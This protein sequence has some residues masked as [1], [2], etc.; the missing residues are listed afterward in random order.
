M[1]DGASPSCAIGRTS[2]RRLG[3]IAGVTNEDGR[4]LALPRAP[5]AIELRH[6]RAF[7]TV[8]EELN[9]GRAA[10]RLYI[11]APALSRQISS[12]EGLVGCELL[13]RSTHRVEL[14]LAGEVLLERSLRLLRDVDDAIST[15]QS[16]GDELAGRAA[17][18]WVPVADLDSSDA[19]FEAIRGAFEALHAQFSPPPEVSTMPVNAGGVPGLLLSS[20]PGLS[21]TLLYL[22]GGG[23]VAGSAF[24]YRHLAGA[25]AVA[26]ETAALVP[27]YRLAPE[28]PF[29]AAIDDA[30]R[31]YLWVLD[32]GTVAAQLTVIADSAGAGLAMSL[33]TKLKQE[34]LPFP[35]AAVLCCP[36]VDLGCTGRQAAPAG[37][38]PVV[39][40]ERA[41]AAAQTYLA[42]HP[43]DD[44]L[45]SPLTADLSGFPPMLIQ[46]ASG[47]DHL[48][49]SHR[50]HDNAR[51]HGVDVRLELYPT[52]T[53]GFHYFWSFLPEAA[54]AVHHAGRFAR[55]I[56]SRHVAAP[57]AADG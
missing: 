49:D 43:A 36:W 3:I 48:V 53:H 14:T 9:F 45:A 24:G 22:H 21:T 44:P 19:D 15:T 25:L 31:A 52:S 29:P 56:Q 17:Q 50:L 16:V 30:L 11:S 33:L 13:R 28:H 38:E 12:L 5:E 34:G 23:Y 8:A 39:S 4:L 26:A 32:R 42:G 37:S 1:S 20:K 35:G 6:L 7:V 51:A 54:D 41:R 18:L 46:A 10:A 40:L 55:D 2:A 47:D 57:A 27:D